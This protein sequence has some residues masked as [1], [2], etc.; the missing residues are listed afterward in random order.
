VSLSVL[1]KMKRLWVRL[2]QSSSYREVIFP[3]PCASNGDIITTTYYTLGHTPLAISCIIRPTG[4]RYRLIRWMRVDPA[5][6]RSL[7]RVHRTYPYCPNSQ[8]SLSLSSGP[9]VGPLT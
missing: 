8:V 3:S 7:F 4:S 2:S 5:P 9:Q 1:M 6:D